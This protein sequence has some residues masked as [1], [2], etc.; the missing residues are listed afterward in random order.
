MLGKDVDPDTSISI[1]WDDS[2]ITDAET[3]MAQ[4]RADALSG[5]IP[6][7]KYLSSR[8]GISEEEARQW[9]QEAQADAQ[10]QET[11]KFGGDA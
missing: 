11:L 8:Y 9:A 1:N 10:P 6:K 3:R 5:L 2:Y 4:M 7:Y